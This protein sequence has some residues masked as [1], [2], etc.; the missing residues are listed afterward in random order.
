[1][2]VTRFVRDHICLCKT[3]STPPWDPSGLTSCFAPSGV[4]RILTHEAGV[5][6]TVVL[7][8]NLLLCQEAGVGIG[9][10]FSSG[11][12]LAGVTGLRGSLFPGSP[13][14]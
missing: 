12:S 5:T 10:P 13:A 9:D 2:T 3:P 4:A 1:M 11:H 14:P 8:V 6:D 7:Q